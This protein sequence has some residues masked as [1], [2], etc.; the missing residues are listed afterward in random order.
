MWL[1]GVIWCVPLSPVFL[2]N[3]DLGQDAPSDW[4]FGFGFWFLFFSCVL[5]CFVLPA[6]S[7]VV[8]HTSIRR[9]ILSCHLLLY[10]VSSHWYSMSRL[11]S[12]LKIA[13]W[14]H[15]HFWMFDRLPSIIWFP[16]HRAPC[17]F[18]NSY[19][20]LYFMHSSASLWFKRQI[21]G[22]FKEFFNFQKVW[23]SWK[24]FS[25]FKRL[26]S[27]DKKCIEHLL[28]AASSKTDGN[29]ALRLI[30]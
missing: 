24:V 21:E 13:K 28:C 8:L 4:G 9:D 25:V 30:A 7:F 18:P 12:S 10:A 6:L 22:F 1:C 17:G 3:W 23:Q 20:S 14:W 29:P 5:F 15:S 19:K 16:K 11:L 2:V 27:L 26:N